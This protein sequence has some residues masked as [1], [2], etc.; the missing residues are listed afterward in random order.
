MQIVC[1]KQKLRK[2]FHAGVYLVTCTLYALLDMES[3]LCNDG[4]CFVFG[5]FFSS[6]SHPKI[7]TNAAPAVKEFVGLVGILSVANR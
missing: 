3:I 6:T 7:Q 5:T 4:F 1:L 2:C